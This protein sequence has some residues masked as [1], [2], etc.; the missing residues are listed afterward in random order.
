[1]S[2]FTESAIAAG[3]ATRYGLNP[4][5][6]A[7]PT[8]FAMAGHS[9]GGHLVAGAAG[10]LA[11]NGAAR[12]LVGV[13]TLDGV[14][15]GTTMPDALVKLDAY[16]LASGHYVPIREIG[17][18]A[19][20]LNSSSNVKQ[21]LS[22]ARPGRF[23]GVVLNGG[24]HMDSMQGGNPSSSSPPSSPP[25]SRSHGTRLRCRNSPSAGSTTGSTVGRT[26]VTT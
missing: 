7:L 19:N 21:A 11:E 3:Y 4:E 22:A 25:G 9:L 17:A 6:A 8:K 10:F 23:N 5:T 1:M 15:L 12:E 16:E 14:P 2:R 26:S 13:I 18:P 24:V 20:Y